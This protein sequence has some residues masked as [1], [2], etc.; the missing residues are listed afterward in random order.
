MREKMASL[1]SEKYRPKT[2]EGYIW[3]NEKQKSQILSYVKSGEIPHLLFTGVQGSGKTTL[4]RIIVNELDIDSVDVLT[5][6]ASDENSV[7]DI[8]EKIKNFAQ[9]YA[10]GKF[11]IVQLEEMDYL[12]P[13][14]QA[15]LR[16]VME[17]YSDTCRFIGTCNYINRIIP[18]IQS[19]FAVF[20]Y[21]APDQSQTMEYA[22]TILFNE[23]VEFDDEDFVK[24]VTVAYPDIRKL[25]NL[26]QQHT[27]DGKLHPPSD[28]SK[29]DDY[30][31]S[32]LDYLSKGD[33][34]GAR[35]LVC[36]T[37]TRDGFEE[38][39]RFLYEN[40]DNI[41]K[42]K[43]DVGKYEG[44]IVVIANYLHRHAL[45]ADPEIN[46]AACFIELSHL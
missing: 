21:K 23:G 34:I 20:N 36:S 16:Q 42:F 14:A 1:W 4:S 45:V 3:Q 27:V 30:K 39:Y 5:V 22:A 33:F 7:D 12:T 18:A 15:V 8:R 28:E 6:N 38:M 32:L 37:V 13:N 29:T 17:E 44:A 9:G 24:F 35:K 46:A 26:L 25:V 19:R 43:S 10:F 11:R 2:V 40:M 31:F 41:P